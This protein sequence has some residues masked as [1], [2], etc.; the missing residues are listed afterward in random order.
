MDL[1]TEVVKLKKGNP[2]MSFSQIGSKLGITKDQAR[3]LYVRAPNI[4]PPVMNNTSE[5]KISGNV[6]VVGDV[7]V[8]YTD[9]KLVSLVSEIAENYNIKQ[10]AIVG[11]MF[12]FSSLS[13]WPTVV[14]EPTVS[15]ELKA[16]RAILE[17]WGAQ[18]DQFYMCMGN[19]DLR[20]MGKVQGELG[21]DNL[22]DLFRPA[23]MSPERIRVTMLDRM[24]LKSPKWL[25]A[26]QIMYSKAK[27]NVGQ[28]LS[29]KYECNVLTHHQHHQAVGISA[30]GKYMIADNGC[31]CDA[32]K[33]PYKALVTNG[34]P[35]WCTGF[36]MFHNGVYVPYWH[37]KKFGWM[38][39]W[40]N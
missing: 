12:S 25:L 20:L 11:D 8:P 18:F 21:P 14:R 36:S 23:N 16:A 5:I 19:H 29:Q 35:E 34:F 40:E 30:N 33:T 1:K 17:F 32:T 4:K 9:W 3:G 7:H 6:M 37:T 28:A 27:L 24:W 10:L 38:G 2:S 39:G 26:H 15:E 13:K 31:L 22:V